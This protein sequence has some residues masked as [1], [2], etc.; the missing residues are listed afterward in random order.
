MPT[1]EPGDDAH[2]TATHS[3]ATGVLK[4]K[5]LV[6]L[7]QEDDELLSLEETIE[8][9]PDPIFE[10]EEDDGIPAL[11]QRGHNQLTQQST[12]ES[13]EDEDEDEDEGDLEQDEVEEF[14]RLRIYTLE[15]ILLSGLRLI[16][17]T[18]GRI[19][20]AKPTTNIERFKAH[21]GSI[22]TVVALLWQDLQVT[23][24]KKA[25]VPPS[26]RNF[27]HFLM[28]L[29]HLKRY[30]T[31]L[32]REAIFDISLSY[33][34]FWVWYFVEKMQALKE[35][36]IKWPDGNGGDD[37]W[38][39]SVDGTHCWIHE[40]QH[41]TWSMDSDY[42]SHK[43]AKAGMNYE[44]GISLTDSK[45]IWM[46]GPFPAGLN[47]I[48]IFTKKGLKQKLKS[49]GKLAIGDGG[50]NGHPEEISS[51]NAHDSKEV[52]RFKSRALKR[53][54]RFNGYTKAFDCLSGRFR[55]STD[56]FANCFEA[57]CVICQYQVENGYDLYDILL[58]DMLYDMV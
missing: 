28:A 4:L 5:H 30:P 42:Y 15:E 23:E 48:T 56:R 1:M 35:E 19:S 27:S 51:T 14:R 13:D 8:G 7:T 36:K 25:R 45:L 43:Y 47:D 12:K 32:E 40:P 58:E 39:L 26:K 52:K 16:G 31:E 49:C 50:Y 2:S 17:F 18:E 24:I 38:I 3:T 6:E 20:R 34:R 22:P 33:G 21:F 29:H 53:H 10:E 11:L 54:E 55:H 37:I 41:P 57:V 44:L 46:N 9:L